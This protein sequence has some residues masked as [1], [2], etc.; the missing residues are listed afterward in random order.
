MVLWK[1]SGNLTEWVKPAYVCYN[2]STYT[3]INGDGML[4]SNS[5]ANQNYWYSGTSEVTTSS[6]CY[7]AN[8]GG[9]YGSNSNE[10]R[11]SDRSASY[12]YSGC[13]SSPSRSS[14]YGFRCVRRP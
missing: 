3:G 5:N 6:T 9:H 12:F 8:K 1:L 11:T 4:S 10:L 2:P 13:Y 7:F 14:Y